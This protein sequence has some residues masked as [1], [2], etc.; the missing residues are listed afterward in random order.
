MTDYRLIWF[1]HFH[2]AAGTSIVQLARQNGESFWKNNKNANPYTES[3]FELPLWNYSREQLREFVDVCE[4]QGVTFISTEFGC[5]NF[6][7]LHQDKR[8]TSITALRD[9]MKRAVSN[10]EY[11]LLLGAI[12]KVPLHNYIRMV[13]L[14]HC[15]PNYYVNILSS[16]AGQVGH[17][18]HKLACAL[19]NLEAIN[20]KVLIEQPNALKEISEIL[21]WKY[22]KII[23]NKSGTKSQNLYRALRM[24]SLSRLERLFWLEYVYARSD[25]KVEQATFKIR[26]FL[27]RRL[28]E[29]VFR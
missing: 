7:V 19:S 8:I 20:H 15:N 26:S 18:E 12:P 16:F 9:P 27:D 2:K 14:P 17:D 6:S 11:D 23:M 5:P 22:S 3:G 28:I 13:H 21:E 1:Q 10:Y 4:Q 24:R 29:E 25:Y